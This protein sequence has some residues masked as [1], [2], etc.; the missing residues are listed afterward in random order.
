MIRTNNISEIFY[1]PKVDFY[2]SFYNNVVAGLTCEIDIG[3]VQV[4]L[5]LSEWLRGS[6]EEPA[7]Y[8]RHV[9][10]LRDSL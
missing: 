8:S 1:R 6:M 3:V 5:S 7:Y 9:I 4:L 2:N 10:A